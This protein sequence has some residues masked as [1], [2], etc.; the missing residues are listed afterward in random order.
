[1]NAK[2]RTVIVAGVAALATAG[3]PP[4]SAF[5]TYDGTK[6]VVGVLCLEGDDYFETVLP[7]EVS[8]GWYYT[9]HSTFQMSVRSQNFQVCFDE[10]E[11]NNC[12]ETCQSIGSDCT[13]G[14]HQQQSITDAYC[15]GDDSDAAILACDVGN[16]PY[17]FQM[18][19]PK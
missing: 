5:N 15:F 8:K 3:P 1:M 9:K 7:G 18:T 12:H 2:I 16:G 14:A 4:A 10:N 19:C 6:E 11:G 13:L 17:T